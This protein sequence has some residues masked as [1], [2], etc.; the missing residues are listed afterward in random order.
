MRPLVEF[1]PG[2][3]VIIRTVTGCRHFYKMR[4]RLCELG[5]YDGAEVTIVKNDFWGP[6]IVQVFH[7]KVALGC[8]IAH[9]I[10]AEKK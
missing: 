3:V 5:L 8:G 9:K 6:V 4:R 1:V 7:S 2:D 10:Y